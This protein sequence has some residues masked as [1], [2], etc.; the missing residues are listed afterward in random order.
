MLFRTL[1]VWDGS[2]T[3]VDTRGEVL[4]R[5][6]SRL[7][8]SWLDS[9]TYLQVNE[10]SWEDGRRETIHFPATLE[11][12]RLRFDTERIAGEAWEIGPTNMVLNWSYK[13]DPTGFL[14]E[15]ITLTNDFSRKSRTWQHFAA[16]EL[17]AVTVIEE[18]RIG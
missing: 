17:V 6:H 9:G 5:H 8:C 1:G 4:D 15:L 11:G 7:T 16:G 12:R 18:R 14:W 3:R 10:Y 2:Y 13:H